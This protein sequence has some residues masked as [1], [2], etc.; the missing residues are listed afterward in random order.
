[1]NL[2]GTFTP[3][4]VFR[5]DQLICCCIDQRDE[6]QETKRN[7]P[8]Q[9]VTTV[10]LHIISLLWP[11]PPPLRALCS[12]DNFCHQRDSCAIKMI[13]VL[14]WK[15]Y[16]IPPRW[17]FKKG[18]QWGM[19]M[20]CTLFKQINIL[21]LFFENTNCH[22]D[23]FIYYVY[24]HILEKDNSSL[25]YW[26]IVKTSSWESHHHHKELFYPDFIVNL[27]TLWFADIGWIMDSLLW[28]PLCS[29][30]HHQ[31]WVWALLC[32]QIQCT[33]NIINIIQIINVKSINFNFV[34][35]PALKDIQVHL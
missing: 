23:I 28:W 4:L 7:L 35:I 11:R 24:L 27:L 6:T 32:Y 5:V 31:L 17:Y 3:S 9:P 29:H 30:V 22:S 12:S 16:F 18:C 1:M 8:H 34:H 21:L 13:S 20:V 15:L 33:M 26:S 25:K 19:T 10:I 14:L 2:F